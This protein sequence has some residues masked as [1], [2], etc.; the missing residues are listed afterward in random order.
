MENQKLLTQSRITVI[1]ALRGFAL[2]GVVLVHM[3]QHY[4]N[5]AWG[6]PPREPMFSGLDS[7]VGWL[8]ANV[9]MGRFINIFAFLFGMSFFIQMDRAAQKGIDFRGRFLWRM[10]VLF[11]IG[12]VGS[13]FYSGDILSLYA[14]YGVVLVLLYKCKNW[15][16]L[17]LAVFLLGGG[18]KLAM[19]Q[20]DKMTATEQ[21]QQMPPFNMPMPRA[22]DGATAQTPSM[23]MPHNESQPMGEGAEGVVGEPQ[24]QPQN[25]PRPLHPA[26]AQGEQGGPS[27]ERPAEM[28]PPGRMGGGFGGPMPQ[29]EKPSFWS[30]AKQ[31]LIGGMYSKINY[32][33]RMTSRGFITLA[34]FILGFI[35]GRLRFFETV[36]LRRRRNWILLAVF[37]AAWYVVGWIITL[38]PQPQGFMMFA[39][40]TA[41]SIVRTAMSDIQTVVFSAV[42]TMLF[43]VLYQLPI[44]RTCLDVLA[45]YGKMG[46]TNYVSQSIIGAI[47]FASWAFGATF[48]TWSATETFLLGLGVYIAQIIVSA[49]W[50]KYFKYGPLEWFWR[51]ATYMKMQPFK[52]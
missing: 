52:K 38:F 23:P 24:A 42:L 36:H 3:N 35:V 14:V 37:V 2:L 30:T 27:G 49:L 47:L 18:P 11:V 43:V 29:M 19:M 15:V 25:Q 44:I 48:G 4:S 40:P 41:T 28:R 17:V 20:Y 13:A 8:V 9:L 21:Q 7:F 34:L 16:L 45:P 5:F 46:L 31:N 6:M 32:Q 1:D 26:M 33:Y 22:E 10:V 50:L 51:T 39:P 12:L